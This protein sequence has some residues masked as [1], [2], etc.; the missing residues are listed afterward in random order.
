MNPSTSSATLSAAVVSLAEPPTR[1]MD[2][3]AMDYFLMEAVNALR[4]SSAV[5]VA[6]T[7]KI[8]QEMIEAGLLVQ[9]PI[10]PPVP[11]KRDSAASTSSKPDGSVNEEEEAVRIRLEAIG[12][13][14]GA[15]IAERCVG[16]IC[17]I[18]RLK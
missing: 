17:L 11:A 4:A 12:M 2:G 8:E 10:P 16:T 15:N 9:P 18:F 6:R 13:H 3:P 7:K 14:V 1:L 5:A